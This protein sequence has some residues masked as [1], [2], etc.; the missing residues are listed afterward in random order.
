M[1]DNINNK[2][3][4]QVEKGNNILLFSPFFPFCPLNV[5]QLWSP[6]VDS[7]ILFSIIKV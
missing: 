1:N 3:S 4:D 6:T 7:F 5:I 2:L